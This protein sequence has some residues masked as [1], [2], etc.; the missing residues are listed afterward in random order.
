MS[1]KNLPVW[2]PCPFK[3]FLNFPW[4]TLCLWTLWLCLLPSTLWSNP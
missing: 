4:R 3:N 1:E 2:L